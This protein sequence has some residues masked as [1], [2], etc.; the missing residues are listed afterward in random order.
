MNEWVMKILHQNS[1]MDLKMH[2]YSVPLRSPASLGILRWGNASDQKLEVGKLRSPASYYTSHWVQLRGVL[3]ALPAGSGAKP[4]PK[5]NLLPFSPKIWHLVAT[6]LILF[7][8]INW[9]NL[10][11]FRH[12]VKMK[13]CFM[14][15]LCSFVEH[16]LLH[17]KIYCIG[18]GNAR[19]LSCHN[20]WLIWTVVAL[21]DGYFV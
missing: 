7:L 19:W 17:K 3:W 12:S 9:P 2:V 6:I 10:I 15:L 4:Q 1:N 16:H 8:G 18:S 11:Q 5:L 13:S 20:Q 14:G 21:S